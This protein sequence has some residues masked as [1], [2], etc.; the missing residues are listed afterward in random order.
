MPE[1]NVGLVF[2]LSLRPVLTVPKFTIGEYGNSQ[3]PQSEVRLSK[4]PSIILSISK[5]GL[6]QSFTQATF[7][8][9]TRTPN[10]RSL[11]IQAHPI[12]EYAR[13]R[14]RVKDRRSVAKSVQSYAFR[15]E[16]LRGESRSKTKLGTSVIPTFAV[17]QSGIIAPDLDGFLPSKLL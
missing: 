16:D 11:G 7:Y 2:E 5:T 9:G 17:V 14:I 10:V 6:P 3:S 15:R 4:D 1:L 8:N 13:S 12:N